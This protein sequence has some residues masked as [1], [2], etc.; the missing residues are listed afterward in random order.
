[1]CASG[2]WMMLLRSSDISN[3]LSLGSLLLVWDLIMKKSV[4]H[5]CIYWL[6]AGS[7]LLMNPR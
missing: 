4:G 5:P 1:M 3:R 6:G 2:L 7:A